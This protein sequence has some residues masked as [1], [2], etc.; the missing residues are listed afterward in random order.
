MGLGVVVTH[1][2]DTSKLKGVKKPEA[3]SRSGQRG[4]EQ[5]PGSGDV[6]RHADKEGNRTVPGETSNPL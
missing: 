2:G 5:A 6:L 1:W 4:G 3:M